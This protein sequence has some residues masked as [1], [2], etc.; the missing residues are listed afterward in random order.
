MYPDQIHFE[1]LVAALHSKSR[2]PYLTPEP[3][4]TTIGLAAMGAYGRTILVE[5]TFWSHGMSGLGIQTKAG[6]ILIR[7]SQL[8]D[9][10][11]ASQ[12]EHANTY[13]GQS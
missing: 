6:P 2:V 1:S 3:T 5:E 13:R 12:L 9:R 8:I 7:L 4:C 11:V 10:I